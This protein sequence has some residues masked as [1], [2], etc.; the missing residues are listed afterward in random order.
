VALR[1]QLQRE[2]RQCDV[3]GRKGVGAD[4]T[5]RLCGVSGRR[6]TVAM[7]EERRRNPETFTQG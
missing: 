3:R 2:K 1:I 6:K 5:M 7:L 4:E